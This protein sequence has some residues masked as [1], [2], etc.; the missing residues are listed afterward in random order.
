[1]ID[2][3]DVTFFALSASPVGPIGFVVCIAI[4][5]VLGCIAASNADDCAQMKCATGEPKVIKHE[6]LCVERAKP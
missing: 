3:D 2:D 6:C 1:M 5:I 4:M